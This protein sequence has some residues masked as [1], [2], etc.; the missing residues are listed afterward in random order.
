MS[1]GIIKRRKM[2]TSIDFLNYVY[3]KITVPGEKKYKKIFGEYMI[4]LNDKPV[5]LVCDNTVFV[6]I[7]PA[8]TEFLTAPETGYPYDGAKLHYVIEPDDGDTL[9]E[10]IGIVYANTP[11]PKPKKPKKTE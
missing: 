4:Y 10:L 6:K 1:C 7:I 11:A 9:N 3:E 8:T 2:A 5:L